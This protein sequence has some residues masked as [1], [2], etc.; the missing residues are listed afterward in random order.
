[1]FESETCLRACPRPLARW[2]RNRYLAALD[3]KDR[4][5]ARGHALTPPR[6]LH[7]IGGG[8]FHEI[9]AGFLR[10]FIELCRL[11]PDEAVLD[12]GCGTGRMAIPL[13]DYLDAR[14]SYLGF[15]ISRKAVQWCTDHIGARNP[16]FRF[17]AA[18][19]WNGD[20]NPHGRIPAH[21]YTFPCESGTV[22]FAFATS[23]FTHMRRPEVARYLDELGRVLKPGG[24]AMLSFFLMDDTN[25]R[26]VSGKQ[27]RFAFEPWGED[28]YTIDPRTPERAIAY[29]QQTVLD[30]CAAAALRV[31]HPILYGSWSGRSSMLSTQDIILVAP[32]ASDR[33][34]GT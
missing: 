17:V 34:R 22:D 8:D 12:I 27:S 14:G 32:S 11:R 3:L 23:V 16:R 31:T 6:S 20:Y 7:F 25:R 10:H 9:G 18:D 19:I 33:D 15:D 13:L 29:E 2:L 21:A 5:L 4:F 30:L 1:M 26:L 24:R 28:A